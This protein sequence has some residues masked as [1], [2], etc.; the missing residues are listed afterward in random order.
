MKFRLKCK[1]N[2]HRYY[3]TSGRSLQ[4]IQNLFQIK[5]NFCK[6]KQFMNARKAIIDRKWVRNADII[7]HK[8]KRI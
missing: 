4:Y 8:K 3:I 7:I 6:I 2:N 1:K 5:L